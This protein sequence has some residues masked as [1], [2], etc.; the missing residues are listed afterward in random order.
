MLASFRRL[1]ICHGVVRGALPPN[2]LQSFHRLPLLSSMNFFHTALKATLFPTSPQSGESTDSK[3]YGYDAEKRRWTQHQL[4]V[5]PANTIT[6][7][8]ALL[9]W[10]IDFA[11]PL[12]IKRVR[13]TLLHLETLLSGH[14]P[15]LILLQEVH[16]TCFQEILSSAFIREYYELTNISSRQLYSTLTLIPKPLAPLVSSISRIP[17]RDTK[18]DRDCLYVDIDMPSPESTAKAEPLRIR[19]A[20][21]HLESL[22]G[23]GDTAR[24][25]QLEAIS[26]LLTA[27]GIGGGLVAG[28]MNAISPSD[29]ELPERLGLSDA[30]LSSTKDTALDATA[31][32][33][34]ETQGHTWGYQPRQRFP[35]NRLD[36]ILTVGKLSATSIKR[37]GVGLRVDGADSAWVSDHYGLLATVSLL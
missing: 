21:T 11:N 36:K 9:S 7:P 8:F 23:Y 29:K 19:I 3:L 35:P 30:W 15:T 14:L 6:V 32:D 28:D 12:P 1:S 13:Q 16:A 33:T 26:K 24:P 34:G 5:Q 37:V 25:K 27:P 20:N 22:R 31:D 18:M 4:T 2:C 17:F 10:N